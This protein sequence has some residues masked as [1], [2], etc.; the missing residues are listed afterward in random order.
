MVSHW[1]GLGG[2]LVGAHLAAWSRATCV[3][4]MTCQVMAGPS[5]LPYRAGTM[6]MPR[7][8]VHPVGTQ[9]RDWRQRRRLSQLDLALDAGV[10][11]RHLSFMETGRALPSRAMLLRLAE[12]LEVPLRERNSLLVAAGY[13]PMY[14]ERPL[15]DPSM[16]PA[17]HAVERLLAGHEP[18][19]ALAVDRHWQL[20]MANPAAQ[21]LLAG[22][23]PALLQPPVNVLRAALHP[24]GLAPRILNLADFRAHLLA[25]LHQQVQASHDGRL[26]TLL[27]E[28]RAYPC[29]GAAAQATPDDDLGGVAVALKLRSPAGVLSF[30]T[31]TTVFGSAVDV[32]VSEL[33]LETFFPADAATQQALQRAAPV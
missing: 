17:R 7:S 30:I 13:A 24:H 26:Q 11:A 10:S 20:L 1:V 21:G 14:A 18:Y 3:A 2:T 27:D 33:T 16:A 31:T 19:P 9:L 25:R 32:T 6:H 22:L 23:E 28:L 12:R 4:S 8:S 29:R 5:R 15:Q